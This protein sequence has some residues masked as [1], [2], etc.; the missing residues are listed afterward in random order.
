MGFSANAEPT[1]T[2]KAQPA[3]MLTEANTARPPLRLVAPPAEPP[4]GRHRPVLASSGRRGATTAALPRLAPG[5][6]LA[7][8]NGDE[9]AVVELHDGEVTLGRSLAADVCFDDVSVSRRHARLFVAHQVALIDERSLNGVWVNGERVNR[10][11]V[12]D[13]D[14]IALG[15]VRLRYIEEAGAGSPDAA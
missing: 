2:L 1:P 4:T 9:V 5:R 12:R 6:Y 7:V 11:V 3:R 13:G 8:D 10:A 15:S 14:S